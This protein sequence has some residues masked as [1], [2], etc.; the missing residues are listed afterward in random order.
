MLEKTKEQERSFP[1]DEQDF[2]EKGEIVMY[3]TIF[4]R[5]ELKYLL[6]KEQRDCLMEEMKPY[7]RLDGFGHTAIRNLYYD[8]TDY[9]LI[10]RSLEKPS[11]KEKLRIRSYHSASEEDEVFVEIKKKYESV[12]YKR[13]VILPLHEA[14]EWL[15][16]GQKCE[17]EGQSYEQ[18]QI[19]GE[20]DYFL[21]YY[22][23]LHPTM[24]LGYEREAFQPVCGGEFRIT[25]DEK[26][27]YRTSD[28]S[29]GAGM[30]GTSLLPEN[31]TLMEIKTPGGIPLWMTHFLA[32]HK[33]RQVSFSKYGAAYQQMIRS[34]RGE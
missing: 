23:T 12:V 34:K 28:L 5:Y 1:I 27:R 31:C 22:K 4:K 14:E 2:M 26:I 9:R 3:Q 24:F 30:E 20:I 32:N 8:T 33:I 18:K 29:L 15:D 16:E 6:T 11:Y 25:L 17:T 21:S 13:R 19:E 7:M 10:R